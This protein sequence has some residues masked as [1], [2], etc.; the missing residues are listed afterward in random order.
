MALSNRIVAMTSELGDIADASRS[1]PRDGYRIRAEPSGFA[2]RKGRAMTSSNVEGIGDSRVRRRHAI[3]L[4]AAA[5]GLAIVLVCGAAGTALA[6]PS[7]PQQVQVKGQLLPVDGSPGVYRVSGGLIGTYRL[8]SERVINEWTER[9]TQIRYIE[10]TGSIKGCVD[11]NQ[12]QSCDTGEPSGELRLNFNRV[13]T[14]DSASGRLMEGR[15]FHRAGS[16]SGRFSGGLLRIWDLPVGGSDEIVS[17]YDGDLEVT[18][19]A[20]NSK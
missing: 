16:S 17:T 20:V 10:G 5:S 8:R 9:T 11:Q 13:A 2:S 19:A 12:N 4:G 14:F 7:D 3:R 1:Q 6:A 18:Q 15:G